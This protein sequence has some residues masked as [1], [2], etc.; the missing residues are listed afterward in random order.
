MAPPDNQPKY[1]GCYNE[2]I[3]DPDL[4]GEPPLIITRAEA[5]ITHCSIGTFA[6]AAIRNKTICTCGD[7]Y[8]K[9]GAAPA[10]A[11]STS[12]PQDQSAFED[13]GGPEANSIYNVAPAGPKAPFPTPSVRS[14]SGQPTSPERPDD[15]ELLLPDNDHQVTHGSSKVVIS[16]AVIAAAILAIGIMSLVVFRK[17]RR[18]RSEN[19]ASLRHAKDKMDSMGDKR[20]RRAASKQGHSWFAMSGKDRRASDDNQGGGSHRGRGLTD[21]EAQLFEGFESSAIAEDH[22]Q[23]PL[24]ENRTECLLNLYDD[25]GR[26]HHYDPR[27]RQ[28]QVD[29]NGTRTLSSS[30]SSGKPQQAASFSSVNGT[31]STITIPSSPQS[32][33][34]SLASKIG[35][36]LE[37]LRVRTGLLEP[38]TL[39]SSSSSLPVIPISPI[40]PISP[41]S[42]N[43]TSSSA[44]SGVSHPSTPMV[45]TPSIGA[46]ETAT[47]LSLSSALRSEFVG[48][49]SDSSSDN[50][51][52]A[53]AS[54]LGQVLNDQEFTATKPEV[55]S[56]MPSLER[57]QAHSTREVDQNDSGSNNGARDVLKRQAIDLYDPLSPISPRPHPFTAT[58]GACTGA[59]SIP[60]ITTVTTTAAAPS[61][62]VARAP[63]PTA[64][65]SLPSPPPVAIPSSSANLRHQKQHRSNL[66][67]DLILQGDSVL[68]D[69]EMALMA[70][71]QPHRCWQQQQQQQQSNGVNR[72]RRGSSIKIITDNVKPNSPILEDDLPD[73]Q[74]PSSIAFSGSGSITTTL[75]ASMPLS[76]AT[77]K[78][79]HQHQ[80]HKTDIPPIDT[81]YLA[82]PPR[83][84]IHKP[85]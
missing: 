83:I 59:S 55:V 18:S 29:D 40:S 3:R 58:A 23:Y 79:Q 9:Y 32:K 70:Q 74:F 1:L 80:Q 12:C 41:M 7:S 26:G 51:A 37:H 72:H 38:T 54:M 19:R 36:K 48:Y 42:L 81:N 77:T 24:E 67:K 66:I 76:A 44:V 64:I 17:R 13:C 46:P 45:T 11:C 14:P 20:K 34:S 50:E 85:L 78:H 62:A 60:T 35:L 56:T 49:G 22:Y 8:N 33:P 53:A 2:D 61:I 25:E 21:I 30:C 65:A 84:L 52:L 73:D 10:S 39:E 47:S 6:Y 82:P 63:S 5:C 71:Y 57:I 31:T 16:S 28:E 69:K 15:I 75:A 68:E 27:I 4:A 43:S